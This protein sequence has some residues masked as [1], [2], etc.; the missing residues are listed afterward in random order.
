MRVRLALFLTV[1]LFLTGS[2]CSLVHNTHRTL[3]NEP[4]L[5]S[6]DYILRKR[7]HTL[8]HHSFTE[9]KRSEHGAKCQSHFK[10]GY[11]DGYIDQ[12]ENGGTTDPPA[13]PPR[14]YW[15]A[16][17]PTPAGQERTSQYFNG[18]RT[19]AEMALA[20]GLRRSFQA[21]IFVPD[22]ADFASHVPGGNRLPAAL[23]PETPLNAPRL[24]SD[25]GNQP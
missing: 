3:V 19:G 15:V 13:Q 18:F 21:K 11:I 7:F 17:N 16:Q 5:A 24:N 1:I 8:A 10:D 2:G 14:R 25:A 6:D 4:L 20:S 22:S 23:P 9:Y 12:L